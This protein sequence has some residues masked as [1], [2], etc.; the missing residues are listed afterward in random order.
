MRL[1]TLL[2]SVVVL[3]SIA[4]PASA[5]E[6]K[7]DDEKINKEFEFQRT[8]VWC[9]AACIQLCLRHN[10]V[11][12][13]Q[14]QIVEKTFGAAVN[15]PG[16]WIQMTKRLNG[17]MRDRNNK[18]VIVSGNVFVGSPTSE[19]I[20]NHLKS[21]QPIIIAFRIPQQNIGHAVLVTGVKYR[22]VNGRVVI[23]TVDLRDPFPYSQQH[24]NNR[25]K[26]TIPNNHPVLQGITHVWLVR[27]SIEQ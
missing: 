8:P 21:D 5:K 6:A 2:T 11:D 15:L 4:L 20:V 19:A 26:V 17:V 3:L 10:D 7:L 24:V 14:K 25:G 27:S 13:T 18:T 1:F 16:N 23:E 22:I 9:W 12:V